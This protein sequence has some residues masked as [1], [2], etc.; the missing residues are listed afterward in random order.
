MNHRAISTVIIFLLIFMIGTLLLGCGVSQA[1]HDDLLSENTELKSQLATLEGIC[2]PKHFT[3]SAELR[4][5]LRNNPVSEQG[6]TDIAESLYTKAMEIQQAALEDGYIISVNI[7]YD[8]SE[9]EAIYWIACV[10]VINGEIWSWNPEDDDI[11]YFQGF[12]K[13]G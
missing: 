9:A 6:P 7:D 1:E 3:S 11:V 2:P 10:A 13:V 5:W 8:E 12:G 4:E